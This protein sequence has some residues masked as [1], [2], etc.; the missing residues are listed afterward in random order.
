[1]TSSEYVKMMEEKEWKKKQEAK[2]KE[3]RKHER[4]RK[5]QEWEALMTKKAQEQAAIAAKTAKIVQT[6]KATAGKYI[7]CHVC[8]TKFRCFE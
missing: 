3:R 2:L 6:R 5:R 7:Q 8:G 4:E 1:M